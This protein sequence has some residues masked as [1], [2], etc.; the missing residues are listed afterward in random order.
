MVMEYERAYTSQENVQWKDTTTT[1]MVQQGDIRFFELE[2]VSYFAKLVEFE[3]FKISI[4]EK[5]EEMERK[6][7]ELQKIHQK[8]IVLDSMKAFSIL[9]DKVAEFKNDLEPKTI[10][11]VIEDETGFNLYLVGTELNKIL[12]DIAGNMEYKFDLQVYVLTHL[13]Y[14]AL[15]EG[16]T[17]KYEITDIEVGELEIA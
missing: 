5:I 16:G 1:N 2:M 12:Y 6:I 8:N 10:V 11:S 3:N 17:G 4:K 14:Q 15:I 9:T 13:Q 7:S